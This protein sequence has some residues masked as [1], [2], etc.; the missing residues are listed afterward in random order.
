LASTDPTARPVTI[1]CELGNCRA[2]R[3]QVISLLAP[4]G[5]PC[6]HACHT[7]PDTDPLPAVA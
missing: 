2:C 3:G 7:Q 5:Q 4:T 1:Q 6:T